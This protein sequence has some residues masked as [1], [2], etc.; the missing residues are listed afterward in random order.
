MANEKDMRPED[1]IAEYEKLRKLANRLDET[2]NVI[3]RRLVELE[4]VLLDEYCYPEDRDEWL[5]F[6]Q[7]EE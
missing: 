3:E 4:G 7:Q 1:L 6:C 2:A 5:R